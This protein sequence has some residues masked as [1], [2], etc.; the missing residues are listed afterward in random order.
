M[1]AVAFVAGV[2]NTRAGESVNDWLASWGTVLAYRVAE[3]PVERFEAGPAVPN[4]VPK[5]T[6]W[7]LLLVFCCRAAKPQLQG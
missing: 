2:R 5:S 6:P 4:V 7:F 3:G 1:V